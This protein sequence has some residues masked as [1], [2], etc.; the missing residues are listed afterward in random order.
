VSRTHLGSLFPQLRL[1]TAA[2]TTTTVLEPKRVTSTRLGL[3]FLRFHQHH[4]SLS[5]NEQQE[6]VWARSRCPPLL[7]P[8]ISPDEQQELIWACFSFS[9]QS[10]TG[11]SPN[12]HQELIWAHFLPFL[13]SSAAPTNSEPSSS[14]SPI[15]LSPNELL[16]LVWA[17]FS[18]IFAIL[19]AA[20]INCHH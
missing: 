14:V 8:T 20:H 5:P 16:E 17:R 4:P 7:S 6:L 3:F 13:P 19:T 15:F 18:L 11:L 12:E 10:H 1:S 2:V 9:L